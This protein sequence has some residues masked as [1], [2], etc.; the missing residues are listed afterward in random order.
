MNPADPTLIE[1]DQL[2]ELFYENDQADLQLGIFEECK[3]SDLPPVAGQLLS[4]NHHMTV[5]VEQFHGCPVKLE[6]LELK[7]EAHRYSRKILLRRQSDHQPVLW[8]IV[9]IDLSVVKP[10]VR[11]EI[12][13]RQ[14]PLGH[15]MIRHNVLREVR[16]AG[17]YR[18]QPGSDLA[19]LMDEASG[20]ADTT[21][22]GRTALIYF[23][24]RPVIEL[25]EIVG[26]TEGI[27]PS[28]RIPSISV[29]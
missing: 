26:R 8:G 17:L 25:L 13:S 16:L 24:G 1:L 29:D 19:V 15:I 22:F 5:T 21:L 3:A 6:V 9:R 7:S 18:I 14:T 2:V 28:P 10:E 11:Q 27:S 12:E 20:R 4:H 23:D